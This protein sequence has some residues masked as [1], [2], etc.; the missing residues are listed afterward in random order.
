MKLKMTFRTGR[1]SNT[2]KLQVIEPRS[3]NEFYKFWCFSKAYSFMQ[4]KKVLLNFKLDLYSLTFIVLSNSKVSDF[5]KE[6]SSETDLFL[7]FCYI[8]GHFSQVGA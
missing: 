2:I 7:K 4:V 8:A 5:F 3:M 1:S 6:T